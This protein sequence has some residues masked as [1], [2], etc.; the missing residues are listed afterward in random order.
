MKSTGPAREALEPQH[1]EVVDRPVNK[2]QAEMLLF[3]REKIKVRVAET[4]EKNAE[5]VVEVFNNGDRQL[6]P[7]GEEVVCERRF[8]E[9]L[10]RA[11]QTTYSQKK[12]K[13][14]QSGIEQYKEVPHVA[15]RYPFSIIEDKHP[16]GA[17]WLKSVLAEA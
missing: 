9:V 11:K 8:V 14:D 15:L 4:T 5:R 6:F 13:D 16:R 7:R 10:A 1:V 3:S 17:D 12:V 2:E